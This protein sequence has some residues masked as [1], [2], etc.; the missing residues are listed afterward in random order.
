L[1]ESLK[2]KNLKELWINLVLKRDFNFQKKFLVSDANRFCTLSRYQNSF[3]LS[4]WI[5]AGK[6]MKFL[7]RLF[8][9][10]LSIQFNMWK[11]HVFLVHEKFKVKATVQFEGEHFVK[12]M[13]NENEKT[14]QDNWAS[15]WI[16]MRLS[17]NCS[18]TEMKFH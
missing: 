7:H 4:A 11:K 1:E 13:L 14:M 5:T 6:R 18:P 10:I 17:N 15:F 3:N 9:V 8:A 12:F 2:K 16:K